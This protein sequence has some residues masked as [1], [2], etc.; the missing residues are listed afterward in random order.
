[1]YVV[2]Y[3]KNGSSSIECSVW[4]KSMLQLFIAFPMPQPH[5]FSTL[6]GGVSSRG[7]QLY[8]RTR[9][10]LTA[11]GRGTYRNVRI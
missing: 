7:N 2:S 4:L 11:A 8:H 6:N 10:A 3:A 9:S 1:M 5:S